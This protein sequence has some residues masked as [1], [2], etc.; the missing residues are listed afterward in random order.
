MA[1]FFVTGKFAGGKR[2]RRQQPP[3]PPAEA[4]SAGRRSRERNDWGRKKRKERKE[5]KK[6]VWANVCFSDGPRV[7]FGWV[8]EMGL[9]YFFWVSVGLEGQSPCIF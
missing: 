3:W 8:L 7:S 2:W 6:T 4:S 9:F 1:F 5:S